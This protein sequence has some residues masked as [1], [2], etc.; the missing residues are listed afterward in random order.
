MKKITFLLVVILLA[1]VGETFAQ[2]V[3]TGTI[4]DA[5]SNAPLPGANVIESRTNNGTTTDFD[6]KF[7]IKVTKPTGIINISY[8]GFKTQ[9]IPYDVTNGDQDL[10]T[11]SLSLGNSLEEIVIVGSGVV[12]LAEDRKTPIAVA[13]I[14]GEDIQ[15]KAA[16]NV[17]FTETIKNTP[18]VYVS[19]QAG[20]FGDSQIFLRGFDDTNTAVLL[21][22]QPI[23]S[24]EDGRV[25]WSNWA[26]MSDVANA[27]QV[28]RGLGSS[29]LAISSVGGTINIV[30]KSTDKREGGYV[31]LLTGN[32][33]Y[34][35]GT[36]NYNTGLSDSGW[37]FSVLLDHWQAHRKYSEGTA[38]A[39]QNY[40][41]SVG[42][43]PNEQNTFN[44]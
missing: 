23:N 11:V 16:G 27:V 3:V 28:Q 5:E 41:F 31:R 13:T 29:K 39:G 38:G 22:G 26:G 44:L 40:L 18:S 33:S 15:L 35:K 32:D 34:A 24:P 9:N 42:Y 20:G 43:K 21:N 12:D 1:T 25:F 36:I 8:V 37:A 19:N 7:S 6:G 2:G 4:F 30:S 10:G 17:E 14:T